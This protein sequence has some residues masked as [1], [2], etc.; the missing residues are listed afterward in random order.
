MVDSPSILYRPPEPSWFQRYVTNHPVWWYFQTFLCVGIAQ[1]KYREKH[2]IA[3][4]SPA[5][6]KV[7]GRMMKPAV[8]VWGIQY[9]IHSWVQKHVTA[10]NEWEPMEKLRIGADGRK[11]LGQGSSPSPSLSPPSSYDEDKRDSWD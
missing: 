10:Y 7:W 6:M 5:S 2:G 9:W 4:G 1:A 3:R 11:S 8:V